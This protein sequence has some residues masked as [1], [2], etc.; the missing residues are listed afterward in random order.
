MALSITT[1]TSTPS[2]GVNR[3]DSFIGT[4]A[5]DELYPQRPTL[6][7]HP[8]ITA[9]M[10]GVVGTG[11][12]GEEILRYDAPRSRCSRRAS[13]APVV[14]LWTLDVGSSA[15]RPEP[16][17]SAGRLD[18]DG[19]NNELR[20]LTRIEVVVTDDHKGSTPVGQVRPER[21]PLNV[22]DW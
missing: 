3:T 6:S 8:P 2:T 20:E 17:D 18:I 11:H 22:V 16:V 7:G 10:G 1:V 4:E 21:H 15:Q 14:V 19:E 9:H 12:V 13:I 5:I